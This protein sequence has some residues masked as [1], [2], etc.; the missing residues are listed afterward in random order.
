MTG[1]APA[2]VVTIEQMAPLLKMGDQLLGLDVGTKTV[3]VALSDGMRM[4]ASPLSTVRRKKFGADVAAIFKLAEG[5]VLGGIVIGLPM[6]MNGDESPRSQ[7]S[8][9][10]ARNLSRLTDLPIVLQDERMTTVA[11]ERAM[12]EGDL[13]RAKRAENIDAVA[14]SYILQGAL[15]RLD[16]L[17][18]GLGR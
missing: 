7:S 10:F 3:G 1:D 9:A 13:S 6:H 16:V 15:D 8:R 14:A 4:T 11:A 12:L 5:R 18:R 2:G 17:A